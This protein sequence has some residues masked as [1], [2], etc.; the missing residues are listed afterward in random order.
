MAI[1][2]AYILCGT[3]YAQVST[4]NGTSINYYPGIYN[5][6]DAASAESRAANW[7]SARGW[8]DSVVKVAP[9]TGEYNCHS[10]AWYRSEGGTGN[11]WVNA[12]INSEMDNFNPYYYSSTPPTP[13]NIKNIGMMAVMLR[14][15]KTWQPK[16][17]MDHVGHGITITD[18]KIGVIILL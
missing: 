10:Y 1:L 14:Y 2:L 17:G 11:Y 18:G 12:F 3:T 9:A 6:A 16:F 8:I 5:T 7:L 4:P 15:L 13:K